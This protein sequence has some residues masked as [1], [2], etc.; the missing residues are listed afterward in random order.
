MIEVEIKLSV[1]SRQEVEQ[2]LSQL[3]YEEGELVEELD[4]YFTSDVHDFKQTD[5]ALRIRRRK[6]MRTG[7]TDAF[8]TYKGR[9]LDGISMTREELETEI[10]SGEVCERILESI[11]FRMVSP[12]RK[13]R[14]YYSLQDITVCV[15]QVE[16]LGD[17]LEVEI[18]VSAEEDRP[19]ALRRIESLLEQLG[20]HMQETTRSSY[21]SML[22]AKYAGMKI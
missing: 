6:S 10:G 7:K 22:Q 1:S 12:V 15:D 11:G 18:M 13:L 21:L 2:E 14:Q 19:A 16:N 5:E 20:H 8:L 9:K 3:K 4:T 17:F